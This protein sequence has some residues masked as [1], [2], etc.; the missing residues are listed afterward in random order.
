ME[1][2]KGSLVY[3]KAGRDKGDL[4]LVLYTEGEYAYL[5][6]GDTRRV[7]KPKKKKIKHINKTNKVL[8][9]DSENISD[10]DVRKAL[11]EFMV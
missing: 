9:I 10:S 1:I 11:S 4:F 8:E 6:D 7:K 2:Q 5:T 3:S